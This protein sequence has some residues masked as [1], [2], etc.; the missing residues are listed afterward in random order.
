MIGTV[1]FLGKTI[2]EDELLGGGVVGLCSPDTNEL[3]S[4]K[5]IPDFLFNKNLNGSKSLTFQNTP[6]LTTVLM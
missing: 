4:R 5:G 6:S 2:R 3:H 1:V